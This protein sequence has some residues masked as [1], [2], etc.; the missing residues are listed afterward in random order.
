MI[1]LVV[2][3]LLAPGLLEGGAFAPP[4][5]VADTLWVTD[6]SRPRLLLPREGVREGGAVARLGLKPVSMALPDSVFRSWLPDA[7]LRLPWLAPRVPV[8]RVRDPAAP[9]STFTT[10]AT[11][12]FLLA[13]ARAG[14][15][16]P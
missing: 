10:R 1:S 8:P 12:D 6:L 11:R 2:T 7:Y 9:E 13:R 5:A 4:P 14:G 16:P 3:L 15:G